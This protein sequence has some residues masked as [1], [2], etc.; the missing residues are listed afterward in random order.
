MSLKSPWKP[1]SVLTGGLAYDELFVGWIQNRVA[2]IA[3]LFI[4]PGEE[5]MK[6]LAMGVLRVIRGEE[7]AKTY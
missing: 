4:N 1:D 7:E 5:E 3:P 6:A 2:W